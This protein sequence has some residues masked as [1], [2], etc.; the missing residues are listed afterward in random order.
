MNEGLH[1]GSVL[2]VLLGFFKCYL[3][4]GSVR[5][6]ESIYEELWYLKKKTGVFF[7]VNR[8]TYGLKYILRDFHEL[9]H[10]EAGK[11]LQY[12]S[13]LSKF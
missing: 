1:H 10:S 12:L 5:D 8:M 2:F 9:H 11:H 3:I 6:C 4:Y 13:L 7:L